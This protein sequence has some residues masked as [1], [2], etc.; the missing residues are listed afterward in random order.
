M[1][2]RKK[3]RLFN[4]IQALT[5]SLFV[6]FFWKCGFH[7]FAI[8]TLMFFLFNIFAELFDF[9]NDNDK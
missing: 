5:M 6:G 7:S 9:R 4:I 1:T 2:T 3:R 8:G